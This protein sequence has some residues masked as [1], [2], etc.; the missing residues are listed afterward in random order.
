MNPFLLMDEFKVV[1]STKQVVKSGRSA[2]CYDDERLRAGLVGLANGL[3]ALHRA[4]IVHRD[5]K[6]TNI[7]VEDNGRVV[8]LD[9]GVVAELGRLEVPGEQRRVVGTIQ[10]M[11]PEQARG[12]PVGPSADCFQRSA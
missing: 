12:E 10:Y 4:E 2:V 8:L 9:F 1:N 6:P 11:A 3:V 7:L 5:V